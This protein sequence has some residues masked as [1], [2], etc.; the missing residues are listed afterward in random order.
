MALNPDFKPLLEAVR[1]VFTEPGGVFMLSSLTEENMGA[2][3]LT[4]APPTSLKLFANS[5]NKAELLNLGL[6]G[7]SYLK[8]K[9]S[10]SALKWL[11]QNGWSD[12]QEPFNPHHSISGRGDLSLDQLLE[13]AIESWIVAYE[14]SPNSPMSLH[15]S[16]VQQD[17]IAEHFLTLDPQTYTFMIPGFTPNV[18]L[19]PLPTKSK[20]AANKAADSKKK[21]QETKTTSKKAPAAKEKAP[22]VPSK[23]RSLKL[24]DK[25]SLA[26]AVKGV[27]QTLVG[28]VIG[29]E[30]EKVKLEVKGN[31]YVKD[32]VYLVPQDKLTA[33]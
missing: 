33:M 10:P 13:F 3:T 6:V 5:E 11:K 32:Q 16:R 18:E 19:V 23:S 27:R 7:N 2:N 9:I 24:G 1:Y 14:V 12:P 30:G 26:F 15:L 28:T 25:A 20:R 31:P 8:K 17:Y 29:F 21:T 4:I 22:K